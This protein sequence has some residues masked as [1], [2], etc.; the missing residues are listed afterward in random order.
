MQLNNKKVNNLIKKWAEDMKRTFSKEDIRMASR[1]MKRCSES[2]I[3]K[4][5]LIKTAV[6]YHL[7]P[8]RMAIIKTSTNNVCS[9]GYREE[10]TPVHCCSDRKPVQTLWEAVRRFLKTKG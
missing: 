5:T 8:V 9:S 1:H 4:N 3:I 2:P 6:G 7:T 10:G